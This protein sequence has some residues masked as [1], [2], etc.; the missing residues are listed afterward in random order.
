MLNRVFFRGSLIRTRCTSEYLQKQDDGY[1]INSNKLQ[2]N[3]VLTDVCLTVEVQERNKV[4]QALAA[5]TVLVSTFILRIF[6]VVFFL[7][8]FDDSK[9][10][11]DYY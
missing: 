5:Q 7:T 3:G 4:Y 6:R 1:G 10:N 11:R 2:C 8:G 9:K